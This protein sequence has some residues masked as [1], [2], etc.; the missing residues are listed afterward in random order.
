MA[1]LQLLFVAQKWLWS[2]NRWI[3][4]RDVDD[5]HW[6]LMMKKERHLKCTKPNQHK[7]S[8]FYCYCYSMFAIDRSFVCLLIP[9]SSQFNGF[10]FFSFIYWLKCCCCRGCCCCCF[11]D[12]KTHG[13]NKQQIQKYIILK[14]RKIYTVTCLN[15][16]YT[17]SRSIDRTIGMPLLNVTQLLL[18]SF[19][20]E[21]NRVN[22]YMKPIVSERKTTSN[23]T[24]IS[25]YFLPFPI[26]FI[27]DFIAGITKWTQHTTKIENRTKFR[28]FRANLVQFLWN[29]AH[30][31]SFIENSSERTK[32]KKT[33]KNE[34]TKSSIINWI[35]SFIS[36]LV[37]NLFFCT[38][39]LKHS[40]WK[41][42]TEQKK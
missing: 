34:P 22:W 18:N 13:K 6:S 7:F 32:F 30:F 38:L 14:E 25:I 28:N 21:K 15:S 41:K 1:E 3:C 20:M 19:S 5:D 29:F 23:H 9:Q 10:F 36:V 35:R 26:H 17:W 16:R 37:N 12:K 40:H 4:A 27:H 31:N 33:K 2:A 42:K 39:I 11:R 24:V 8:P